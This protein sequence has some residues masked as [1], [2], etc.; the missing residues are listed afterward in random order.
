MVHE[1]SGQEFEELKELFRNIDTDGNG[2]ISS[3][4]LVASSM[5]TQ[6]DVESIK[7]IYDVDKD[8]KIDFIEYLKAMTEIK[9]EKGEFRLGIIQL[10][11]ILDKNKD[12]AISKDEIKLAF[13][14]PSPVDRIAEQLIGE[15]FDDFDKNG[16]GK[17]TQEEFT[18]LA[19]ASK[20]F[21]DLND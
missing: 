19:V 13:L 20:L 11:Q 3:E 9:Y 1:L 10:Y 17:I 2:S 7:A 15:M 16:D 5:C 6:E 12:G 18:Q 21:E 14:L 8:G 4:E